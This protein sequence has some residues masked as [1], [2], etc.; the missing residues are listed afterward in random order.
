VG[1]AGTKVPKD[2]EKRARLSHAIRRMQRNGSPPELETMLVD[3]LIAQPLPTPHDQANNLI[4]WLGDKAETGEQIEVRAQI[5][6]SIIGA[7]TADGFSL[8]LYRTT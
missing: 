6:Q 7:K 8:I 3:R 4:L 5:C 2:Q 1:G